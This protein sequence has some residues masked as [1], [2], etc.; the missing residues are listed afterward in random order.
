MQMCS[1]NCIIWPLALF[2]FRKKNAMICL[3]IIFVY[4]G[5][6]GFCEWKIWRNV[7]KSNFRDIGFAWYVYIVR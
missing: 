1:Y 3:R 7:V 4:C 2:V 6:Q 5:Y